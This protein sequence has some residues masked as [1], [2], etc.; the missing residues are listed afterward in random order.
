MLDE[1]LQPTAAR[2]YVTGSDG[3]ARA[4]AGSFLRVVGADYNQPFA[5]DSYF[6]ADGAFELD[7]PAGKT[8]IEAVKGF[9]YEPAR[10]EVDL[11]SDAENHTLHLKR[12][13]NMAERGWHSGETHI[14]ANV[15]NNEVITPE[16]VW[17]QIRG[18]DLNVGQSTREQHS[19]V[20]STMEILRR[21]STPPLK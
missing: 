7:L 1:L 4:P 13:I 5:G 2:I 21:I 10:Q 11:K 17:L 3:L 14:H 20:L 8:L 16:D 15:I 18:E 6:Y 9:E 19:Q 12:F